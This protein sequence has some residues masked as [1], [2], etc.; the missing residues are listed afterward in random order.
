MNL[1]TCLCYGLVN[2]DSGPH[3]PPK[4]IFPSKSKCMKSHSFFTFI[5][6]WVHKISL[7][8][9]FFNHLLQFSTPQSSACKNDKKK[10]PLLQL[11]LESV[12]NSIA[13]FLSAALLPSSSALLPRLPRSTSRLCIASSH[14]GGVELVADSA[15][16]AQRVS[17]GFK[18]LADTFW[19]DVQRAE[20][21]PLS[22]GLNSPLHIGETKLEMVDNVAIRVELSNGCVGWGEVQVLPLVT[23]VNLET[24]LGKAEDICSYLRRTPP[25]TLNSVFDDIAGLL[26]PREFAPVSEVLLI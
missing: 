14:G 19:V 1:F 6:I 22:V 9:H 24:A 26:S 16:P 2:G 21:R 15:A 8:H 7:S 5:F 17:F 25:A 18:N 20:G 11:Q 23:D 3:T 4:D 13:L 12:A 10:N